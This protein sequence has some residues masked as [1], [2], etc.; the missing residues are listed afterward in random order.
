M[1]KFKSIIIYSVLAVLCAAAFA[2]YV[3]SSRQTKDA[4]PAKSDA[5]KVADDGN[6][7][8][9]NEASLP[10]H[11]VELMRKA[12]A[13]PG[14]NPVVGIGRG[15]DY[16]TVIADA[17]EKA[18]G[19]QDIIKKG[20]TVLI[21]PNICSPAAGE[22]HPST[23]DHRA[24][25]KVVD[26]VRALGASK[27]IVAEGPIF[28]NPFTGSAVK[29]NKYN[30]IR[31]AVLLNFNDLDKKDCYELKPL[32]S[33]TG[34]AI[35][36]PKVYMDADVVINLAKLKTHSLVEALAT[37]SLKNLFGVPSQIIYGQNGNKYGLHKLGIKEAIVDINRIRRPEFIII[38]GIVGGQGMGPIDNQPVKSNIVF[39]GKDP[40]AMDTVALTFMG[41]KIEDVIH[42]KFASDQ[43]LGISDLGKIRIV[44][45]DL[46][47]IKMKFDV[48][49]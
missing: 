35:F 42:V 3:I 31:G 45:A 10:K 22:G 7:T 40:V 14:A 27:V 16:G 25:Q 39:A 4:Q 46:D 48:V 30:T 21:K 20:D 47:S 8:I 5:V 37:L 36:I 6:Q 38:E 17:V 32:R 9:E 23:V 43:G 15:E 29:L 19:L 44:G 12:V 2:G 1:R 34:K 18:G 13:V 24:T 33:T 26:M 41:L 28:G 11:V 49:K